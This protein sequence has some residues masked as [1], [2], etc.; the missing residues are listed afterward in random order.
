MVENLFMICAWA[1]L[2]ETAGTC[3]EMAL[4]ENRK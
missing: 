3:P 2:A 4:I 1:A